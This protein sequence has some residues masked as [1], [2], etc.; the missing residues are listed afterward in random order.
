MQL[1]EQQYSSNPPTGPAWY[2]A[3]NIVFAIGGTLTDS[4]EKHDSTLEL[5]LNVSPSQITPVTRLRVDD[6]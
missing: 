3:L 6:T 1:Y 5:A 2:A 4:P